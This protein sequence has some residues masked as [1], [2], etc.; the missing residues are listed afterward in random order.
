MIG[1]EVVAVNDTQRTDAGVQSPETA[2]PMLTVSRC[3]L[4]RRVR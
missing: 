1:L 4:G 2:L 3:S